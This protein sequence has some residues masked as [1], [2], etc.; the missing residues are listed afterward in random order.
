MTSGAT[1]LKPGDQL[2]GTTSS[3][4]VVVIRTPAE[5]VELTCGGAPM[6]PA[7]TAEQR[8][9]D[10]AAE[11]T[12]VIGKRYESADGTLEVLC[13]ASGAGELAVGG[14]A[15]TLKSAKP[16]PASD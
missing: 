3:T 7:A 9:A 10:P 6:V 5:P 14:T 11:V 13:T 16:L 8:P 4:R 12:T 1:T 2:A 15:L